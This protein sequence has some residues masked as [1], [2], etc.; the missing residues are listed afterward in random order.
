MKL[1]EE[2]QA[3]IKAITAIIILVKKVNQKFNKLYKIVA[4]N[5]GNKQYPNTHKD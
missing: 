3:Q 4:I 1:N 5:K 2:K